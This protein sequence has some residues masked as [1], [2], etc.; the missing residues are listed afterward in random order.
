MTKVVILCGGKGSRLNE[1]APKPLVKIGEIPIIQHV[2]NI[3]NHYNYNEFILAAGYRIE[4]FKE[5]FDNIELPYNIVLVDTGESSETGERIRRIE[6]YVKNERFCLTYGDGLTDANLSEIEEE[7]KNSKEYPTL[8]ITTIH[9]PERFGLIELEEN[10]KNTANVRNFS[11]KPQRDDWINGG[12]M[13]CEPR[14]FKYISLDDVFEKTPIPRMIKK[15]E[16]MAYKYEGNWGCIDTQ[17]DLEY[18][19]ELYN[20]NK[21]YWIKE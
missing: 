11:E 7:H 18:F 21:S 8:T 5:Y 12:F 6:Q 13:V 20:K 17:K 14:I 10:N 16:V 19:R 15:Q 2:M 1:D 4:K 9:P 3:Y